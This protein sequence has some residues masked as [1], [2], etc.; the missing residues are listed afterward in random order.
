[1]SRLPQVL[2]ALP[3]FP[4]EPDNSDDARR[5]AA[6]RE[7]LAALRPLEESLGYVFE[8]PAILRV[9]LTLGSW[10]H[11]HPYAGWPSNACLEFFGDAVL[12]LVAA[13]VVWRKFPDLDEG[14]LTRLRATLV[15]EAALFMAA[16][17]VDLGQWLYLSR[18]QILQGGRKH[19]GT[20]ADAV[21]AVL[22]AVFLD[23][24]EVGRPALDAAEAVF[25]RMLGERVQRLGPDHGLHPKARLQ[26]WA[27]ARFRVAPTYVRIGQR[28]GP[29]APHWKVHVQVV[30]N[31]GTVLV[32][33]SGE[34]R[35]LRRAE[36]EAAEEALR[37]IDLR[38]NDEDS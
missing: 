19:A 24:R 31:E 35:S 4:S 7:E 32:L 17:T 27:Q 12:D 29:D 1:M 25:E 30:D 23:A 37:A 8:R 2:Q 34:G 20:L 18:G 22:G 28:P 15:S 11:E 3:D 21:E 10:T 5:V 14:Q 26:Q 36:R 9:A 38:S 13:D 16:D 6:I 33:G